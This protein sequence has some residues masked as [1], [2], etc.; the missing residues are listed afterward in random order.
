MI[1]RPNNFL[2]GMAV[3]IILLFIVLSLTGA[4]SIMAQTGAIITPPAAVPTGVP[5]GTPVGGSYLVVY[6]P[7]VTLNTASIVSNTD[8]IILNTYSIAASLTGLAPGEQ[9]EKA[10][11]GILML[12]VK[13]IL[14]ELTKSVVNW[15]NS[16]FNGNPSFITD[17]KGWMQNTADITIGDF[18]LNEPGLKFLCDPFKINVQLALG[19]QYRPFKEQIECSFTSALGNANDAMNKFL[20]G[21]F[22]G[23]GGWNSWLQITTQPQNNYMG[24]MMIAQAEL[25]ARITTNQQ[26]GTL[27]ANWGS[28]FMAW[29]KC[30]KDTIGEGSAVDVYDEATGDM[31]EDVYNEN[32]QRLEHYRS[33]TDANNDTNMIGSTGETCTVQTPGSVIVDQLDWINSSTLRESELAQDINEIVNALANQLITKGLEM[34]TGSGLLGAGKTT[35]TQ[36]T[37]Y[38][39]YLTDLEKQQLMNMNVDLSIDGTDITMGGNTFSSVSGFDNNQ[40]VIEQVRIEQKYQENINTLLGLLYSDPNSAYNSFAT[41][42]KSICDYDRE[43]KSEV[44]DRITGTTTYSTTDADRLIPTMDL[45]VPALQARLVKSTLNMQTLDML[46]N[47]IN[48]GANTGDSSQIINDD[49]NMHSQAD[50]DAFALSGKNVRDVQTWLAK[51]WTRY[52]DTTNPDPRCEIDLRVWGIY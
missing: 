16:G 24:A 29:K 44:L 13:R 23:G 21:D 38:S 9:Q 48:V 27:E 39:Q 43:I 3:K 18:L 2:K 42:T 12:I 11:A 49:P 26:A 20:E 1:N 7:A 30:E 34:F 47:D 8:L 46:S 52:T 17:T 37:N 10:K 35:N 15:I 40:R 25:D 5:V 14:R 45:S 4:D 31:D 19:L 32:T 51:M 50:A 33:A 6:D 28:G 41:A 22:I 36:K